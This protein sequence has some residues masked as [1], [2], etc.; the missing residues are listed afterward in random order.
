MRATLTYA[1]AATL[2]AACGLEDSGVEDSEDAAF[3]SADGKADGYD[4]SEAQAI[5]VMRAAATT[6]AE[7]KEAGLSTRVSNNISAYA[8]GKDKRLGTADDQTFDSL[9][10]LDG[11][12]YVGP[13][14]LEM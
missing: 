10:E 2:V 13:R 5:A 9:A 1:V 7:L 11:I 3:T 8:A 4:L 12:P 14:T 6:A